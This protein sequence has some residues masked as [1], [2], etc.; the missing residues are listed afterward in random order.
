MTRKH[1]TLASRLFQIHHRALVR[2]HAL[3]DRLA[4][5]EHALRRKLPSASDER[6]NAVNHLLQRAARYEARAHLAMCLAGDFASN[7]PRRRPLMI[8][9]QAAT[10]LFG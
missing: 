5:E 9:T 1:Q 4:D 8:D 3:G 6:W 7:G 10:N 2:A